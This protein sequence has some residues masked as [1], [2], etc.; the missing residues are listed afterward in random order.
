MVSCP[1]PPPHQLAGPALG[2][3]QRPRSGVVGGGGRQGRR[4]T[5]AAGRGPTELGQSGGRSSRRKHCNLE[6]CFLS[7]VLGD[8]C[9]ILQLLS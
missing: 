5:A 8:E 1:P 6:D 3:A 4:R 2:W 9:N 7:F